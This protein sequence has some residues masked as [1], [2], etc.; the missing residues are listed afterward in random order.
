L[1]GGGVVGK[2]RLEKSFVRSVFEQPP[3]EIRHAGQQLAHRT[4]LAHAITHLDQGALDRAR[5]SI[6]QLKFEPALIDAELMR[7][8]L[9]VRNAA[10]VVRT[11]G[12]GD[13]R[14][15]VEEQARANFKVRVALRF[16]EEDRT[17][18]AILRPFDLFVV[19]VGAFN[20]PNS[21]ARSAHPAPVDQI[22]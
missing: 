21:E 1:R 11:E 17:A 19:P 7:V 4:I 13:D 16:L 8:G 14:F 20:Q 6:K 12:R 22:R 18:P 15:V 3:H 9:R 10:D 5:H 2:L